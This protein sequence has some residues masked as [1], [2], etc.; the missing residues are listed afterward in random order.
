MGRG[1]DIKLSS[2]LDVKVLILIALDR[3]LCDLKNSVL[4]RKYVFF[5]LKLDWVK[6]KWERERKRERGVG[7]GDSCFFP[8]I[9]TKSFILSPLFI[10]W[11]SILLYWKIRGQRKLNRKKECEKERMGERERKR[12]RDNHDCHC[13]NILGFCIHRDFIILSLILIMESS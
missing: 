11:I 4:V 6:G 1:K 3:T 12:E 7:V 9:R 5:D 8:S 2:Y 10:S 13:P